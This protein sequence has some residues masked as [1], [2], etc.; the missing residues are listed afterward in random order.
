[1][2]AI[3]GGILWHQSHIFASM[4]EHVIKVYHTN[5]CCACLTGIFL[6]SKLAKIKYIQV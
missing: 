5:V 4:A 6:F 2:S 1:M 3:Y